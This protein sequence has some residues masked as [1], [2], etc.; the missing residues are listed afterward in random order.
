MTVPGKGGRP[1]VHVDQAEKSRAHRERVQD[2]LAEHFMLKTIFDRPTDDL[3]RYLAAKFAKAHDDKARAGELLAKALLDGLTIGGG[4]N[5]SEAAA[6][7]ARYEYKRPTDTGGD[8]CAVAIGEALPTR[9]R[10]R[11]A[12]R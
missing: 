5:C 8:G 11:Q 10:R 7:F 1:R 3:I 6:N 9:H 12:S 2:Q 4:E